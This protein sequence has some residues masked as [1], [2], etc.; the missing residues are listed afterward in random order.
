ME[1]PINTSFIPSRQ[2]FEVESD[3]TYSR[4]PSD[5]LF[6][7]GVIT[8][9]V[10]AALTA[11]V[12]LY[13]QFA[14][15]DLSSKKEQ[16]E[17]AQKAFDQNLVRELSRLDER[18]RVAE[19]LLSTHTAPSILFSVL[20]QSTL[21]SIQFTD[22]EFKQTADQ[23]SVT[24]KG[25]A[26]SVNGVALQANIFS[27]NPVI[28]DPIFENLDLANDGRIGFDVSFLLNPD[29]VRYESLIAAAA[30]YSNQQNTPA[31]QDQSFAPQSE[32][33]IFGSG[34]ATIQTQTGTGQT[35]QPTDD[36]FFDE[37]QFE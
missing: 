11:G 31:S 29:Y 16:L 23:L 15:S 10:A 28:K 34:G 8:L 6:L 1:S 22:L 21:T 36:S 33:D 26:A 35:Q 17:K 32:D 25:K 14:T 19:G 5:L 13:K 12:F 3:T 27:Q 24:M 9:I 2:Q 18:L 30:A 37:G 20:E 7:F 4:G